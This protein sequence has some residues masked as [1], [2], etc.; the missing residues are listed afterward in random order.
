MKPFYICACAYPLKLEFLTMAVAQ[1]RVKPTS[2]SFAPE[3]LSQFA[4]MCIDALEDQGV[5]LDTSEVASRCLNLPIGVNHDA[6]PGSITLMAG[7]DP[8]VVID[9]LA[10]PM[11]GGRQ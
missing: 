9:S 8:V 1:A 4:L 11:I 7:D 5:H 6:D 10:V 3:Q 2:W